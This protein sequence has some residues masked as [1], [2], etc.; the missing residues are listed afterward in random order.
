MVMAKFSFWVMLYPVLYLTFLA[1]FPSFNLLMKGLRVGSL[2]INGGRDRVKRALVMETFQL[3]RLDIIFLQETHT[4]LN[5]E[6]EWGIW[7][8]GQLCL[9]HG[10]NVSAG[11][12]VLFSPGLNIKIISTVEIVKGRALA[13]RAEIESCN[14]VFVNIYAPNIGTERIN[15]FNLLGNK[16]SQFN[17]DV[18][19]ASGDWN[20]TTDFLE[21]RIGEEPHLQSAAC[22]RRLLLK[23]DLTDA[24]RIKHPSDRQYTWV[25]MT[26][27][28][29]SAARLDRIYISQSIR[30]KLMNSCII[31]VGFTDHHLITAELC[32]SSET[33]SSS[34]WHFNNKL[35]HDRIFCQSFNT[36]WECWRQKK[37]NFASLSQWWEVGKAQIRVFCQ[38]YTSFS[39]VHI[40]ETIQVLENTIRE[41]ECGFKTS[42]EMVSNQ[43]QKKRQELSSMMQE[44][45]KGA[46]VRARFTNIKDMDAPSSFFFNLE[47]AA[48]TGKQMTGFQLPDGSVTSDS[49]G[50]RNHAV[51]FYTE[52]YRAGEC[53]AQCAAELLQELPELSQA[54]RT[55]LDRDF[56]LE[57]LR[58]AVEELTTGRAPGIDGLSA[59][60]YKHFWDCVGVDLYEVLLES[61]NRGSLPTS[62]R[63]A[64]LSLLPKKGDLALLKNWRP[65][66]LLCTDYKIL[67]KA[68]SNRLKDYMETLVHMDQT[69]CVPGRT[70]TDNLFLIRDVL[71]ISNF[72]EIDVGVIS[73]DQQKA[74]DMVHHEFL[75][76]TLRAFG[77]GQGFMSWV[78]LLYSRTT[79]M[80]KIRGGLSRPIQVKRGIRQ[81]CPLSGML[82]N[83]SIEPLLC[84]LRS[85]L[86]GL[87]LSGLQQ[88]SPITV[89]AYADDVTIF[90]KTQED[91]QNLT[92]SLELYEKAASAK[93]NWG[94]SEALLVGRWTENIVPRLPGGLQ[95]GKGGMKFLGV[96][97]GTDE[98]KNK[99]W[100]GLV[101]KVCARLSKWKWLLPQLSYR[102]RALVVNNL[103]AS[104][105]WHRF[106]VL[107]PP[108]SMVR[109]IQRTL[110]D[111]FWTGQHWIRAAA[112]YLPVEEG[113]Q[114][115]IDIA[116]RTMA[117]RIKT[118]KRF[119][120]DCGHKWIETAQLILRRAGRL[121]YSRQLFL[122]RLEEVDLTGITPFYSTVLQ[123]WQAFVTTRDAGE[124]AGMWL[125]EEP[126][127]YNPFIET[128][129]LSSA[130]LRSS[131]REAGCVKVGHL[132]KTTATSVATLGQMANIKSSRLLSRVVEEVGA[133]LPASLRT[134]IS[135]RT[136]AEQWTE[137]TDYRFPSLEVAA[138]T[139]EWQE[140]ADDFLSFTTPQLGGLKEL[141]KKATYQAL[142][143]VSQLRSLAG[144]R[145]SR[146]T[147]L[148]GQGNV[149][150]GCWRSLYKPPIEKRSGDLQWRIVHGAI[151]TN[152]HK[153]HLDPSIGEACF[154]VHI[155]KQFHIYL[156]NAQG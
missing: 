74:F 49:V 48:A 109:D 97:L 107:P 39:T 154:F 113:G 35:I 53:D 13:V 116:S 147:E 65:V 104:M 30:A 11:V 8:E 115:L 126:L 90:I 19:V 101:E 38:Q 114:G 80:V 94:K 83:L 95:W 20:C 43:W 67:S 112:L 79:C 6:S 42:D 148:F 135:D 45:V 100:E 17:Q 5:N 155:L 70:I 108:A 61:H 29:I 150:K 144:M 24:W 140:G 139:G 85:K 64:V 153:A 156:S 16:V 122:C 54:E 120:Y 82:Y 58:K 10:T 9:S 84:R 77:I 55:I 14:Y 32:T 96:F 40:R 124:P 86:T 88:S 23:L 99:N 33:T 44:R 119:L 103:V 28:R 121:G 73:I 102:G 69:Y 93:V 98:Y 57:E 117:Y 7:W 56:S 31:P 41:I 60:F 89:S 133:A 12:A 51:D 1:L 52:L 2:N 129:T 149:P 123:A 63:R 66:A 132:I 50:M 137:G 4:D 92:S 128:Q 3:K 75:F 78:K 111:F 15:F 87:C 152:R 106:S 62:C 143:K 68:L 142:V 21:D 145:A 91:I 136:H 47:K 141:G 110:V 151:A 36:F 27:S 34:Y 46:M 22:L 131:L 71:D 81:G 118:A 130:S 18:M 138:A 134:F 76:S 26:D 146:W 25:K 125:F 37:N 127:F 72:Q 59:D 105:L